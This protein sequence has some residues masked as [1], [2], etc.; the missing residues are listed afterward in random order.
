MFKPELVPPVNPDNIEKDREMSEIFE[1]LAE[2]PV[3]KMT[4]RVFRR[5]FLPFINPMGIPK[6]DE[7]KLLEILRARVGSNRVKREALRGN[8]I[9]MWLEYVASLY[10]A[11]EVYDDNGLLVFT[12][13]P[14]VDR[15]FSDIRDVAK[16]PRI[17]QAALDHA[18]ILPIMGTK[19]LNE[20]LLPLIGNGDISKENIA[21]WDKIFKYYDLPTYHEA[22]N[23]TKANG[24]AV[25]KTVTTHSDDDGEEFE[26]VDDF[27]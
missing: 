20:G 27:N 1:I 14:L 22:V 7:E 23:A 24:D 3:S 8:L 25:S 11:C 26:V 16:I 18:G 5:N 9:N 19:T 10:H 2:I 21:M 4:E 12:V 15:G 17:V 6:E 13:P